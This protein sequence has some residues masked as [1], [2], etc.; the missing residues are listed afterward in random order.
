V[1]KLRGMTGGWKEKTLYALAILTVLDLLAW[2]IS[3]QKALFFTIFVLIP[4]W[5]VWVW[6]FIPQEADEIEQR[7]EEDGN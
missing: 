1:I 6:K 3:Q 7:K 4:L 2:F 5:A